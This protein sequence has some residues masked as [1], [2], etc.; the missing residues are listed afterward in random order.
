[1]LVVVGWYDTEDLYGTL[2]TYRA[3]EAQ[4]PA[5]AARS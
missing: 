1:V 2:E 3:L 4:S 5:R